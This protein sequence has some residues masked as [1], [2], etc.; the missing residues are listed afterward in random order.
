M[1]LRDQ[2]ERKPVRT[3]T[4]PVAVQDTAA[5]EVALEEA[6]TLLLRAQADDVQSGADAPS[7][8]T[9]D[10]QEAYDGA[11]ARVQA[12]YVDV[13]LESMDPDAFE[14]L[15]AEHT[16]EDGELDI[17]EFRPY[18]VAACVTDTEL[19]DADWWQAQ[20]SSKRWATGEREA[21]YALCW[22]LNFSPP[23]GRL[24]KG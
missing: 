22:R 14:V 11:L 19:Q 6:Q 10:A 16:G 7:Q 20:L 21:L 9:L 5:L 24:G 3:A 1:G 12:C 18:L 23:R 4:F 2:L 15:C 8:A 17:D 13:E